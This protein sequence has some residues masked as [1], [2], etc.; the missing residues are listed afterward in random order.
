[1]IEAVREAFASGDAERARRSLRKN[2]LRLILES[3]TAELE[4]LCLAY[5]DPHD[6]H[7][8]LIR[9]CCRDL[10][11]DPYGAE[12]LRGQGLR[13]ASDDFVACFT[14]LLLAPDTA[15]KAVIADR[16]HQALAN[17]ETEDDYPSALFL[18]G[19]TEVRLRRDLPRGI[20]LLRS[21][22]EEA[23]LQSRAET[24]RLA[25]S[26]LAFALTHAGAFTEAEQ[27]LD[28]LP[29]RETASDWDH[30]EGGLPESNRGCIAY[31]RGDFA[32]AIAQFDEI[33]LE[34]SPGTDFEALA[35][36][37]SAM[38]LIALNRKDRYHTAARLLQGVS[39]AD[40]HGIPWDTLRRV[41]MAWLSHA[42]GQDEQA[43]SIARPTLNR[44]GAAVAHAL[45]GELYRVM[46]DPVPS[47][48]ALRLA[49]AAGLPRYALVSTLVTSAA[50]RSAAGYG[51][52][53]HEQLDRALEAAIPERVLA[54]FLADDSVIV[55]LLN[56]HAL[57]GS[58]H[59]E[60]LGTILERRSQMSVRLAGLLT[61]REREVLTY[62][63]TA[64][65][66]DEIAAHL[67]I[68]YPT[69]KTHIRSIYRKLGVTKR[70]AAIQT[71]DDR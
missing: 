18:L 36:L 56:A 43:R 67:G 1:M 66:S 21:A 12:F 20:A 25:Q 68:T 17:C 64:M 58:R 33:I 11:G 45:L 4:R 19:W 53:A 70:R 30:F 69:V 26:N 15:T 49:A 34:G 5:P 37:Y 55:D 38:S 14:N 22:S 71:A 16:A 41:T 6:S 27:I 31:W 8:L 3:H 51:P 42:Q 65:T 60:F 54:P 32:G 59:H 57:R 29:Q 2:W 63:R 48:Q 46:E 9:A 62:L 28:G 24:F 44:T 13:V 50:L 7:V 35:R 40:K 61:Q 52:D 47:T 23:K 39:T 10:S